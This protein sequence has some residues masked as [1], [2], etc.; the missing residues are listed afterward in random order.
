[1][2]TG[3]I[4]TL[5]AAALGVAFAAAA[6]G[7]ASAAPATPALPNLPTANGATSTLDHLTKDA[8]EQVSKA[9]GTIEDAPGAVKTVKPALPNV[10]DQGN[11]LLGGLPTGMLPGISGLGGV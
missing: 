5:G 10:G 2:K 6:A 7:T 1:M 9:K 11:H 4:K 3:T 8:P